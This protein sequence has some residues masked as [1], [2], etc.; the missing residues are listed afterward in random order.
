MTDLC[1]DGLWSCVG[2]GPVGEGTN[3]PALAIHPEIARRPDDWRSD[4]EGEDRILRCESINHAGDILWMDGFPGGFAACQLVQ[5]LACLT[6]V[7]ERLFQMRF[8]LVLFQPRQQR[9]Q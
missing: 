9:S 2:H 1:A 8:I 5:A 3:Q 6:I 4:V 7:L